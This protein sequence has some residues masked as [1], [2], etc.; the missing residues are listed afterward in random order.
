MSRAKT[1]EDKAKD[2][3]A[4]VEAGR[5]LLAQEDASQVSLR[6][7]AVEAAYSPASIY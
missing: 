1:P 2:R 4:F 6:R 3:Q 7:I 5:R